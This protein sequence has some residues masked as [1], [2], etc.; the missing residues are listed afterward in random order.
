MTDERYF[1]RRSPHGESY[2]KTWYVLDIMDRESSITPDYPRA[3][4]DCGRDDVEECMDNAEFIV[5]VLNEHN[6]RQKS[7]Q[8]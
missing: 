2:Q 4:A 7:E 5:K 6:K 3:I 1:I 8:H